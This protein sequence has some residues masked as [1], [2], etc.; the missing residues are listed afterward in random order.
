MA[1]RVREC[2]AD[3]TPSP[4]FRRHF[5]L[6][7]SLSLPAPAPARLTTA[8]TRSSAAAGVYAAA[9]R[10]VSLS[11]ALGLLRAL[12]FCFWPLPPASAH[13]ALST[14]RHQSLLLLRCCRVPG[15]PDPPPREPCTHVTCMRAFRRWQRQS[16]DLSPQLHTICIRSLLSVPWQ[17]TN[18]LSY[19]SSPLPSC[20]QGGP[21]LVPC[22][23][24]PQSARC[25][26][27]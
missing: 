15:S 13:P 4:P 27:Q 25:S 1:S 16:A 18:S 21:P 14:R 10:T 9:P 22:G 19:P 17:Y 5:L 24:A 20:K 11:T 7:R 23:P 12:L 3:G 8:K 2:L 26:S 6:F